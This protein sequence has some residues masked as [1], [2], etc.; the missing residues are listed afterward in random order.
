MRRDGCN[1]LA[2]F[3][4]EMAEELE[5]GG[6]EALLDDL[7]NFDIDSVN[8]RVIPKTDALL[9]QKERSLDP[10][11]SW[12]LDCLM[13]GSTL[14]VADTWEQ[15]VRC[16]ALFDDFIAS[17]ERIGVGRKAQETIFGRDLKRLVPGLDKR[18]LTIGT[19][20]AWHYKIPPLSDCRGA[21]DAIMQQPGD[22]PSEDEDDGVS[23]GERAGWADF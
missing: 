5:G 21:W 15:L 17:A 20:R 1:Q 4:C 19:V 12:W 16:T 22:W 11:A 3:R 18:R 7:L 23:P 10:I 6:Y 2:I 8:L 9:Y 13:A 14:R